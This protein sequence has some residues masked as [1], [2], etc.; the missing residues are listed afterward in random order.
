VIPSRPFANTGIDFCGPI[1]IR[2]R[3][4][5]GAKRVKA[6]IAVFIC[7]VVKAIHLEVVSDMTT[8]AFLN[9]FKRFISRRGKPTNVY[10]DNGTNFVGANRELE[11]CRELFLLEQER[12]KIIDYTVCEGIR[13][14]FIPARAPHFGGLWERVVKSFKTHF[15]KTTTEAAMTFEEASTLVTQIE[16]IFNSHP[17]TTLSNDPNNLS[18][19]SPG[20]FLVGD[21]LTSYPEVDLME[22]KVN[23]LSRWQLLE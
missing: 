19:L 11:K 2:E 1:F 5:R 12:C 13:W 22:V 7:M 17:L 23:R 21:T 9:A 10:S 20:H 15:Y 18:Y 6:Y 8:E 3:K 16:A 14:H 4:G